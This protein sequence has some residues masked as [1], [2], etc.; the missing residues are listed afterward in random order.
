MSVHVASTPVHIVDKT[1]QQLLEDASAT[2]N[3]AYSLADV[4]IGHGQLSHKYG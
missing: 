4:L 3:G 2:A 1:H